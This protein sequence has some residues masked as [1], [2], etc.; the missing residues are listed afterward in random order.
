MEKRLKKT[1]AR[2]L[3]C[4]KASAE[5]ALTLALFF[6]A[7]SAFQMMPQEKR[8]AGDPIATAV[9]VVDHIRPKELVKINA[10]LRSHRPD[11]SELESDPQILHRKMISSGKGFP[12]IGIPIKFSQ[13]PAGI[14][15]EAPKLG[16]DNADLT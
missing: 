6:P 15:W 2:T 10:I 12:S 7:L 4:R 1:L 8:G 3:G 13:T 14:G 11:I 16:E 5:L 9:E